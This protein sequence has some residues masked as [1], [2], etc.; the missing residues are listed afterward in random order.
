MRFQPDSPEKRVRYAL[1][2]VGVSVFIGIVTTK[3]IGVSVLLLAPSK[4]FQVYYFRMY[5]FLIVV[6]FFHGFVMLPI[7][8]RYVSLKRSKHGNLGDANS[9]SK[10][11]ITKDTTDY[12]YISES[13]A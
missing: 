10:G 13:K 8:L 6:G 4:V 12:N 9:N 7:F 5:F 11:Q 3:I 2:N 1:K